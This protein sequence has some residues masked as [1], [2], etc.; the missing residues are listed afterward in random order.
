MAEAKHQESLRAGKTHKPTKRDMAPLK[1]VNWKSPAFWPII[2]AAARRQVGKP[3][4][5]KLVKQLQ[6]KDERFRHLTHQ[7]VSEW[8]DKSVTTRIVWTAETLEM[9]KKE[10][11]PGGHQTR[12][13]VFVSIFKLFHMQ[14][15][16]QL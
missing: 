7:R 5:T 1:T 4:I 16:K 8:R 12:Y 15:A 6:E 14:C 2:D 11:L 10:F 9:V 3:N 13:N